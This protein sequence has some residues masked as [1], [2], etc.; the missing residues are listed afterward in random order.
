MYPEMY[1]V[2]FV[3]AGAYHVAESAD[4]IAIPI[5]CVAS[6]TRSVLRDPDRLIMDV[7]HVLTWLPRV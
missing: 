2:Y 6:G 4:S 3:A 7:S 1:T 5:H